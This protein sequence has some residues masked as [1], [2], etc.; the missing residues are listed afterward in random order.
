MKGGGGGGEE[1]SHLRGKE[2][3][4]AGA[5]G[6]SEVSFTNFGNIEHLANFSLT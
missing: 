5:D 6:F 1:G 3:I 2:E 4:K